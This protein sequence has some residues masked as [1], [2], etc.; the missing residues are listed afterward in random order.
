M[1]V[2]ADKITCGL[3]VCSVEWVGVVVGKTGR[4]CDTVHSVRVRV[5][6]RS[7]NPFTSFTM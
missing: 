1:V 3:V 7:I 4:A 2:G 6:I 5:V